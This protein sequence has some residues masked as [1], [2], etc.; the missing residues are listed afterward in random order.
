M[1]RMS[2]FKFY[3]SDWLGDLKIRACTM[4]ERGVL[5]DLI[6]L[7]HQSDER[8]YL[9]MGGEPMGI[10]DI[11]HAMHGDAKEIE[12]AIGRLLRIGAIAK[13]DRGAIYVPRM[14]REEYIRKVRS[15][16]GSMGGRPLKRKPNAS[17]LL[18]QN[19]KQSLVSGIYVSESSLKE[20][21]QGEVPGLTP[22]GEIVGQPK[23]LGWKVDA[24]YDAYPRKVGKRAAATAIARAIGVVAVRKLDDDPFDWL[25]TRVRLFADSPAGKRERYTPHPA[26]WF[27][28]GRYD[29]D[30]GEWYRADRGDNGNRLGRVEATPGKYAN[31]GLRSLAGGARPRAADTAAHPTK[32]Q[33]AAASGD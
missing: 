5:F 27:N 11:V 29:D 1:A 23:P 16:A 6:L 8:G 19:T 26:T 4:T 13:D 12:A 20:G 28:E 30:E 32:P 14:A 2:W 25:L 31:V 22:E 21:V 7:S 33:P 10:S 17:V 18:K 24:L 3:A 9:V 15:A